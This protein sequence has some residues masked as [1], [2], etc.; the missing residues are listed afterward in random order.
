VEFQRKVYE[1]YEK[2]FRENG[3]VVRVGVKGKTLEELEGEV[4][5]VVKARLF[6]EEE[7][8]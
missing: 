2:L 8:V 4:N 5:S 3:R 1:V 6:K 7:Q